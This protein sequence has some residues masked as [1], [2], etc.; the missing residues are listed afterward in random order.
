M[1]AMHCDLTAVNPWV[2]I[3]VMRAP[4]NYQP[5]ILPELPMPVEQLTAAG[6]KPL[7]VGDA[8]PQQDY[9]KAPL[10]GEQCKTVLKPL[11]SS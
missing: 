7:V 4:K 3:G 5:L 6:L 1:A 10:R 2:T 9:R 8:Q 11:A